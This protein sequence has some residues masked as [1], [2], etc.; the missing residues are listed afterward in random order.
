MTDEQKAAHEYADKIAAL[1]AS[2]RDWN[3]SAPFAKK[4]N[5]ILI[6]AE[7]AAA[8]REEIERLRGVVEAANRVRSTKAGAVRNLTDPAEAALFAEGIK[9][10]CELDDALAALPRPDDAGGR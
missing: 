8:Q 5:A 2:G 10:L 9:A 1:L 6:L 3:L 7:E 4:L